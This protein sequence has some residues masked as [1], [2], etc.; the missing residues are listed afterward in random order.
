[1]PVIKGAWKAS[2]Y[3]SESVAEPLCCLFFLHQVG[4]RR[5]KVD[6]DP[7]QS[8]LFQKPSTLP[9]WILDP[10]PSSFRLQGKTLT[11]STTRKCGSFPEVFLLICIRASAVP[12]APFPPCVTSRDKAGN[13]LRRIEFNTPPSILCKLFYPLPHC[14]R[15]APM[16]CLFRW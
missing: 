3:R 7:H 1:M 16:V 14:C 2:A 6:G 8:G 9:C 13:L 15:F 5:E 11:T 4:G 10:R 12:C